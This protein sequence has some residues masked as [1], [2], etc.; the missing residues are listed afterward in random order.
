MNY[1][2]LIIW[3]VGSLGLFIPVWWMNIPLRQYKRQ[4][5]KIKANCK[6]CI[7]QTDE[8]KPIFKKYSDGSSI[9]IF[10]ICQECPSNPICLERQLNETTR[11]ELK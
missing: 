6:S 3:I 1:E 2:V 9:T 4:L 10:G 11:K 8:Y 7:K 5:R